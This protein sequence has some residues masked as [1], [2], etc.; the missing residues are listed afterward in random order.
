MIDGMPQERSHEPNAILGQVKSAEG[1]SVCAHRVGIDVPRLHDHL[2]TPP[3]GGRPTPVLSHSPSPWQ[4]AAH[5]VDPRWVRLLNLGR[6]PPHGL[7]DGHHRLAAGRDQRRAGARH[8]GSIWFARAPEHP[9]RRVRVAVVG[10]ATT[11]WVV[12]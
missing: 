7:E 4:V 5:P 1:G 9:G 2:R 3:S 6:T 11:G 8:D 12:L 10:S